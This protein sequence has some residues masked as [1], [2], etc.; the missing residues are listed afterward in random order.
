MAN[1]PPRCV[2]VLLVL[3]CVL[4]KSTRPSGLK[5]APANSV[6]L[7]GLARAHEVEDLAVAGEPAQE[8]RAAAV[9]ADHQ[10][11][12]RAHADVVRRVEHRR[13]RR[14]EDEHELAAVGVDRAVLPHLPAPAAPPLVEL[15]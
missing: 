12:A 15:M 9:L 3:P 1:V 10:P 7:V 14:L 6:A 13:A 2:P 11:A 8:L 5:Q 4:K